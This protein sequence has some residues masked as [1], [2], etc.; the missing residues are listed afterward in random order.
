M[1]SFKDFPLYVSWGVWR[2]RNIGLFEDAKKCVFRLSP[3][4]VGV[5]KKHNKDIVKK[6]TR[7]IT[8]PFFYDANPVGF[9]MVL[10]DW[11]EL[12][13]LS[14]LGVTSQFPLAHSVKVW[15]SFVR[16]PEFNILRVT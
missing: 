7:L 2:H 12:V 14:N 6:I 8:P 3:S 4:I 10:H 1:F 15:V 13:V 9:F 5:Y 16:R 11:V